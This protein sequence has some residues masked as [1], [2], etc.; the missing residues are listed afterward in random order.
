VIES[1]RR[2]QADRGR[3]K[4]LFENL[5]KN[6]VEHGGEDVTVT[7]GEIDNGFYI[8]DDGSGLP[9][10]EGNQLFESGYST[11]KDGNG[12]GLSIV[13]K[14]VDAHGW[15]IHVTD[16]SDGGARFEVTNVNSGV[17]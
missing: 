8:E 7:V 13:K 17:T 15:E 1:E 10:N 5:F 12:L 16:S 11:T 4:Q 2:V 9:D 14:I 3:L 6:A